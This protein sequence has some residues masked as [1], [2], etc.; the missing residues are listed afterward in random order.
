MKVTSSHINK[1]EFWR[2]L[3]EN[4]YNI[5]DKFLGMAVML[6]LELSDFYYHS[7][8]INGKGRGYT[9]RLACS[10]KYQDRLV[11][12]V[13]YEPDSKKRLYKFFPKIGDLSQKIEILESEEHLNFIIEKCV[14]YIL[15]G[16]WSYG[17]SFTF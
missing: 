11:L 17:R 1:P 3:N 4:V 16:D 8:R 12:R 5:E 6:G 2:V 14:I 13:Y 7:R 9:Y 10:L 15:N